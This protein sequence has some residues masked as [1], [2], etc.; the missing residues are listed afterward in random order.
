M[1]RKSLMPAAV[2]KAEAMA[3]AGEAPRFADFAM[4]ISAAAPGTNSRRIP[5]N[6][7][8]TEAIAQVALADQLSHTT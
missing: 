5:I 8:L 1:R 7:A 2:A 3:V 4:R 6:Q